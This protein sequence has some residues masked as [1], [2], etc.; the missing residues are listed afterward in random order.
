MGNQQNKKN[1]ASSGHRKSA[2]VANKENSIPTVNKSRPLP[3]PLGKG[4]KR[5][6]TPEEHTDV[7]SASPEDQ[8]DEPGIDREALAAE[9]LLG[10]DKPRHRDP[11]NPMDRVF[12]QVMKIPAAKTV[13]DYNGEQEDDEEEEEIDELEEEVDELMSSGDDLEGPECQIQ[14]PVVT[15]RGEFTVPFKVPF[16]GAMRNLNDITSKTSF[17]AFLEASA[18]RMETRLSLLAHIAYVPSYWPKTPKPVPELLEDEAD[19]ETLLN[20]VAEYR[21]TKGKTKQ[22]GQIKPF[23]I[24]IVDMSGSDE[25]ESKKMTSKKTT[26]SET[27]KSGSV[28]SPK[29]YELLLQ[30]EKEHMCASCNKP[31]YILRNGDHHVYTMQELSTWAFLMSRH[32][33]VIG[34]PPGELKL[35]DAEVKPRGSKKA[36]TTPAPSDT[37]MPS[38]FMQ[39]LQ[40]QQMQTQHMLMLGMLARSPD[41]LLQLPGFGQLPFAAPI[42]PPSPS[43]L[44]KRPA[45]VDMTAENIDIEIWL[46]QLD[47]HPVRGKRNL[48]YSQFADPFLSN[49]IYELSDIT[50]L[51]VEQLIQLGG[52]ELNFGIANRLVNYAKEDFK[53]S[54]RPCLD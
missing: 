11:E 24:T 36:P 26:A 12:R 52:D 49:G 17:A 4:P 23:F 41:Q 46:A 20:D 32:K 13:G 38:Q 53:S 44:A 15:S 37:T 16:K 1:Q 39:T 8:S 45:E 10:F 5:T 22:A 25:K 14:T 2:R 21:V 7:L 40:A 42:P 19:W 27:D 50:T 31:C 6:A 51:S 35:E 33:A 18:T 47:A 34:I 9:V 29:E 30:L 48:N 3:R 43:P 28:T 54:K